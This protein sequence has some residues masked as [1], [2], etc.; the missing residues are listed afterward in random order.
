MHVE[1][2]A[3]AGAVGADD[4]ADLVLAHV[5]ADVGQRLHAAE[6]AA[7]C[8]R[9][10][11]MTSPI[12]CAGARAIR[13]AA[14]AAAR[15]GRSSRPRCCR[16]AATMPVRPSSNLHLR[17]DVL[18][19]SCRAYSASISTRVLLGDEAAAHLARA[20]Q[21]VVVGV[22]LLVQDQEAVHLRLPASTASRGELGIDL[23][24]ALAGSARR[25]RAS[26]PGRCSRNRRRPRRSAQLPT[27]P[28][29]DVDE[30]AD[31]VALVA[32]RH[33]LLDVREELELVLDVV[34]R[35]HRAVWRSLP[36]VLGA[37][38]D[39]EVAVGVEEAGVAGVEPAVGVDRLRRWR[40]VAC[41]TP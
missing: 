9:A 1:H 35:E 20:G 37:V 31:H 26:A 5:E 39:L 28:D 25:P 33:R 16:S 27:A 6:R 32:E 13:Q 29:V 17:L 12:A 3:L 30:R 15:R 14:F 23:L 11:R 2:R 22:E 18:R 36:D 19:R 38:D 40:R 34:G 21:L 24:D 41:S 4:G 8:S 10:S 7:R